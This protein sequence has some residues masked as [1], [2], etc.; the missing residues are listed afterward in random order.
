MAT[1]LASA[2]NIAA[3]KME[4]TME[5]WIYGT[6]FVKFFEKTVSLSLKWFTYEIFLPKD[7]WEMT[8]KFLIIQFIK[9]ESNPY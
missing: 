1:N 8:T 6:C 4:N 2:Q 3:F 5:Y 7:F 9:T